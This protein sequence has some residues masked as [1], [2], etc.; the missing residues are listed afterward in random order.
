M[1]AGLLQ[2]FGQPF[3]T[4]CKYSTVFVTSRWLLLRPHTY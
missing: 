3:S 1:N 2:M 4:S